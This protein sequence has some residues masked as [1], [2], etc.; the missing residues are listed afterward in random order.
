MVFD[1]QYVS[2]KL[3]SCVP[4][5]S[6]RGQTEPVCFTCTELLC[7]LPGEVEGDSSEFGVP[8]QV[9]QV[10]TQQLK[11]QTQVVPEHKVT[12]QVD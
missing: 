3:H 1:L 7:K 2:L 10:V 11:H 5:L 6:T 12:L 9:V 8:Q 4:L